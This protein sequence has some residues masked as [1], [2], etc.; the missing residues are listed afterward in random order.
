VQIARL[1]ERIRYL[2]VHLIKNKKDK[3]TERGLVLLANRRRKLLKF[4][5]DSDL[6]AFEKIT[7][8]FGIRTRKIVEDNLGVSRRERSRT[9]GAM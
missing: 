7:T 4:L 8:A 2:T 5:I 6:P 9:N 1:S 3:A